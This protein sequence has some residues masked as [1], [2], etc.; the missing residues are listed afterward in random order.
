MLWIDKGYP[1][2]RQSIIIQASLHFN[3]HTTSFHFVFSFLVPV[4]V[5]KSDLTAR[6]LAHALCV[7]VWGRILPRDSWHHLDR[8]RWSISKP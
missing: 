7:Q 3:P 5:E 1:K 4:L 6:F 2:M 8:V